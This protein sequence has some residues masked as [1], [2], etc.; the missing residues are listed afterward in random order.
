VCINTACPHTKVTLETDILAPGASINI[1]AVFDPKN[2]VGCMYGTLEVIVERGP[3]TY[4]TFHGK[5]NADIESKTDLNTV[6]NNI[7][8]QAMVVADKPLIFAT[9]SGASFISSDISIT[10]EPFIGARIAVNNDQLE[11]IPYIYE[12]SLPNNQSGH[13]VLKYNL[14]MTLV[15]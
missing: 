2:T 7:S 1:Q 14:D 12:P 4:L 9:K 3:V 10:G 6:I 5:V 15:I 8:S 13:T 11:L